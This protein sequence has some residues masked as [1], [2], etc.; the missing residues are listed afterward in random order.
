[1]F[2]PRPGW[3]SPTSPSAGRFPASRC[4]SLDRMARDAT[5]GELWIRTPA[6][7]TGYLNLPD[8]TQEVLTSDGWYKSGDVFRRDARRRLLLRWPR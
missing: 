6:N 4:V 2:G 8:K 7:M 3:Q 5:E 1:M